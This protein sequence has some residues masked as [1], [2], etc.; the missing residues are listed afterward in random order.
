MSS[1]EGGLL[2]VSIRRLS[3][4]G[5]GGLISIL[6]PP[7]HRRE[8]ESCLR[9]VRRRSSPKWFVKSGRILTEEHLQWQSL[10][11]CSWI[12]LNVLGK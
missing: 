5:T 6:L 8:K 2:S 11:N 9:R 4:G 12:Y 7:F 3:W 10:Q 1:Q